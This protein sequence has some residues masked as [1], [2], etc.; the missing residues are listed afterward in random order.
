MPSDLNRIHLEEKY[1]LYSNNVYLQQS[2]QN[3]S[4]TNIYFGL[5]N[6]Y[7]S[8]QISVNTHTLCTL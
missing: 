7:E 1:F 4:L 6:N 8:L 2:A 5:G 3:L